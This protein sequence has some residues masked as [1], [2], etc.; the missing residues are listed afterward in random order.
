V[1]RRWLLYVAWALAQMNFSLERV[2][3]G[4]PQAVRLLGRMFPPNLQPGQA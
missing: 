1:D 3:S 2:V 4:W